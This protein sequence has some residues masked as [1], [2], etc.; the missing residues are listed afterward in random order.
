MKEVNNNE[1][2]ADGPIAVEDLIVFRGKMKGSAVQIIKD[3]GCNANV[4]SRHFVERH[5]ELFNVHIR[6][7]LYTIRSEPPQKRH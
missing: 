6:Q 7:Y 5:P 1:T 4:M 2:T 3:D